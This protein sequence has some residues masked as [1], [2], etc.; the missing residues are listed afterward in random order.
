M[1][2]ALLVIYNDNKKNQ[3]EKSRGSPSRRRALRTSSAAR[4][5]HTYGFAMA[6]TVTIEGVLSDVEVSVVELRQ[7]FTARTQACSR[8]ETLRCCLSQVC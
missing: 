6:T 8:V 4:A 2:L 1:L 5:A 3:R 7:K